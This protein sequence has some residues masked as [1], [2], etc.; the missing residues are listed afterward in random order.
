MIVSFK[1]IGLQIR[2]F[3][4]LQVFVENSIIHNMRVSINMELW[5]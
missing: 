5:N 2:T 3:D 1:E 4:K